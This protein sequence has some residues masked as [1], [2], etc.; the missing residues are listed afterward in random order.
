MKTLSIILTILLL[1]VQF[2]FADEEKAFTM[3][4][5]AQYVP[6]EILVKFTKDPGLEENRYF[7]AS[8]TYSVS[9]LNWKHKVKKFDKLKVR[10]NIS[11]N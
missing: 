4:S 5:E 7:I 8:N 3:S 9:V 2:V 10:I 11:T 1:N 6:G